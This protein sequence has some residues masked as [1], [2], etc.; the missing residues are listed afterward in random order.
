MPTHEITNLNLPIGI[1]T[2]NSQLYIAENGAKWVSTYPTT[3]KAGDPATA[4]TTNAVTPNHVAVASD[5]VFVTNQAAQQVIV[6]S[7]ALGS[8][9]RTLNG[10]PN[11][12]GIVVA[13]GELYVVS[14][15]EIRVFPIDAKDNAPASRTITNPILDKP[16]QLAVYGNELFVANTAVKGPGMSHILVFPIDADGDKEPTHTFKGDGILQPSGIVIY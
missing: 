7:L 14:G 16:D 6:Y 8:V 9:R 3:A 5:E 12:R 13:N 1:A 11:P 2:F 10:V 15:N 4:T